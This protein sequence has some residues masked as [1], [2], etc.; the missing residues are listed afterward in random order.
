MTGFRSL[1]HKFRGGFALELLPRLFWTHFFMIPQSF[2]HIC[3]PLCFPYKDSL[4]F[5]FQT[6]FDVFLAGIIYFIYNYWMD[7]ILILVPV[8]CCSQVY[9]TN[10][11]SF[12]FMGGLLAIFV[13][14]VYRQLLVPGNM[15]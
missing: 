10:T 14:S 8:W 15:P 6:H 12:H 5:G 13:M 4:S 2:M 11:M 1:C 3:V 9:L 7:L